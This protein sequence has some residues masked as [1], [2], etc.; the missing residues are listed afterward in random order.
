MPWV[1]ERS[2]AL[3]AELPALS[4]AAIF[5]PEVGHGCGPFAS[6]ESFMRMSTMLGCWN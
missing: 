1:A 3:R 6:T 2:N 4:G 5:G